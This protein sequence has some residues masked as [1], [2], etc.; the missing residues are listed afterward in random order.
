MRPRAGDEPGRDRRVVG[1][2]EPPRRPDLVCK[3]G[4]SLLDAGRVPP[5]LRRLARVAPAIGV[6]LVPGG[7]RSVDRIRT[8]HG[9]GLISE[10]DAHWAAVRVLDAN[11][12]RLAAGCGARLPLTASLAVAEEGLSVLMPGAELRSEDPMLH[13]W[14]VSSDSIAAWSAL[15]SGVPDLVLLKAREG[16]PRRAGK[17]GRERRVQA[18]SEEGLVDDHLP[19]LLARTSLRAWVLNGRRP[20]R[21]LRWMTGERAAAT[22]LVAE[23]RRTRD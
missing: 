5:L 18:A 23:P 13:S 6:L 15:R 9:R 17:G 14:A 2:A 1:G 7:G 21:L 10:E 20:D 11:A 4:G 3:V 12:V 16:V 19:T 22:R 8:R